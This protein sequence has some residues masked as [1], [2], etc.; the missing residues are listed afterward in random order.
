[1]ITLLLALM[2]WG[3]SLSSHLKPVFM[4]LLALTW[5]L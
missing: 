2:A 4:I 1:M 3:Q 5:W